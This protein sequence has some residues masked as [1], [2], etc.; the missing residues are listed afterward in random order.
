[1][2][3]AGLCTAFIFFLLRKRVGVKTGSLLYFIDTPPFISL[4]NQIL[5]IYSYK[6][7]LMMAKRYTG[8]SETASNAPSEAVDPLK[9][10]SRIV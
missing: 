5:P 6:S 2:A 9:A 4:N 10:I 7:L 3:V 8:I 1:V